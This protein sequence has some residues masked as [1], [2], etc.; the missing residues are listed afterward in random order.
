MENT[1]NF[2]K[3][4]YWLFSSAIIIG[5]LFLLLPHI[6]SN[7]GVL[8]F[9]GAFFNALCMGVI[10]FIILKAEFL[11]WFKHFSF[12]WILIGAPALIIISSIFNIAW[13]YFAGSTTE[14]GINSVL[15]WSYVFTSIP[16]MLLGEELLSISLLYAAWKKWNWKFWQASLLCSLLFATWH[17]T[18]YDFNFLQCIITL[19]P[20]RLILNYLFK[21]TN[22][23]W[24]TFIV[25]FIFDFIAFLPVLLK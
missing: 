3:Q 1:S 7:I 21:K 17:L 15:T 10:A 8:E 22:S 25:H 13:A 23:I 11:D 5:V 20:A 6:I 24:V 9:I 18:S 4:G 16:F 14:N 19:A 12:K 2:K